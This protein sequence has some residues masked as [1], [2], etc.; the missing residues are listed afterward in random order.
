MAASSSA[1]FAQELV[2][3]Y[4]QH[5]LKEGF[6]SLDTTLQVP[7]R[8]PDNGNTPRAISRAGSGEYVPSPH[9]LTGSDGVWRVPSGAPASDR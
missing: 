6:S 8:E 5:S 3:Y 7:Y 9:C 1:A 2:D 4:K